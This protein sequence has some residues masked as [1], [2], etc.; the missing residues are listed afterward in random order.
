MVVRRKNW[1]II[2]CRPASIRDLQ[3]RTTGEPE[4]SPVLTYLFQEAHFLQTEGVCRKCASWNKYV[5][6]G[7][8]LLDA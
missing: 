6:M 5:I 2:K 4:G 3:E 1:T 8:Y 7:I